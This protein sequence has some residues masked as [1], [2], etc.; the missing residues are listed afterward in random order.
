MAAE[1]HLL[2]AISQI[3]NSLKEILAL[4]KTLQVPNLNSISYLEEFD[5]FRYH[6]TQSS[7]TCLHGKTVPVQIIVAPTV[8]TFSFSR[9][10]FTCSFTLCK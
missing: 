1:V 3:N 5:A 2:F 9:S 6:I 10:S 7:M 8:N 4:H